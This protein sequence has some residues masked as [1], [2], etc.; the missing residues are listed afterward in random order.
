[1]T[2]IIGGSWGGRRIAVPPR[3]TRPTTDRVRE[4]MFSSLTS[5]LVR[6]GWDWADCSVADLYAG[7]GALGIEAASRGARDVVLVESARGAV[8]V[9]RANVAALGAREIEV[10]P[11]DVTA[12]AGSWQGAPRNLVLADPP[13]AIDDVA[14]ATVWS[15]A[16]ARGLI[17]ESALIAVERP[18]ASSDPLGVDWELLDHRRYGDT[19]VWYGRR[20]A[21]G[22]ADV[23]SARDADPDREVP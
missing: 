9:L 19:H 15:S 10:V 18:A 21:T 8:D 17:A 20:T 3:G 4:A 13:Y 22:G 16:A 5:M 14:L 6:E 12:W 7:S 23:L 11:M 2:R 1:M